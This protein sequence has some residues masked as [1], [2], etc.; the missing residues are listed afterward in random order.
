MQKKD[1]I[2][3]NT[4]Q[5]TFSAFHKMRHHPFMGLIGRRE[6]KTHHMVTRD[7]EFY[8]ENEILSKTLFTKTL[9]IWKKKDNQK[10]GPAAALARTPAARARARCAESEIFVKSGG[11][12]VMLKAVEIYN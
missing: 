4:T 11:V 5:K 12:Y 2:H 9:Q 10:R 8:N 7:T 6:A 3:Q 1:L